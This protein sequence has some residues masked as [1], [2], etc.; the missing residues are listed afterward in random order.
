MAGGGVSGAAGAGVEGTFE[1]AGGVI[2]FSFEIEGKYLP[3]R[4]R[5]RKV[6]QCQNS[7]R[8]APVSR[9]SWAASGGLS[10]R[11]GRAPEPRVYGAAGGGSETTPPSRTWWTRASGSRALTDG[12]VVVTQ[13]CAPSLATSA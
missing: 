13:S 2:K 12:S 3:H 11:S 8:R 10:G 5:N 6:G 4:G 1:V 7:V 9:A